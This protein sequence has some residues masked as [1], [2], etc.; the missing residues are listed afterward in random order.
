MAVT[1]TPINPSSLADPIGF[2][3][4]WLTT[5]AGTDTRTLYLA[6]QC[7]HGADGVL[8]NRGD[9]VGQMDGALRNIGVILAE[10]GM[11]FENVVQLNL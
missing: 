5:A 7:D 3:H 1:R 2:A 6:G 9:L 4:A 10:A 8:R 11:T